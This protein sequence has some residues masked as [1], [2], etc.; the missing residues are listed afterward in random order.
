MRGTVSGAFWGLVLGTTGLGI[1]SLVHEQPVP[2]NSPQ[3][4]QIAAPQPAEGEVIAVPLVQ[5]APDPVSSVATD[6]PRMTPPQDVAEQAVVDA[7]PAAPPPAVV[8]GPAP[9]EP[10]TIAPETDVAA[11]VTT[12]DNGTVTN[13]APK[14]PPAP[15]AEDM[16]PPA[17][18]AATAEDPPA[19]TPAPGIVDTPS[20]APAAQDTADLAAP[21]PAPNV[22]PE[23]APQTA[24]VGGPDTDP[25]APVTPPAVAPVNDA[26]VGTGLAR[27]P[28]AMAEMPADV[29]PEPVPAQPDVDTGVG[30]AT[31]P[32]EDAS[33]V[34]PE[35][36]PQIVAETASPLPSIG[37]GVQVNRPGV[38]VVPSVGIPSEIAVPDV[39][40]EDVAPLTRYAAAF[41]NPQDLPLVSI[42]LL[43]D[44]TLPDA[45]AAVAALPFAATVILD[46][47]N[48]GAAE[49]MA[50]Y[51]AAG[52]EVGLQVALPF[53][54]RAQ[55]VEVAFQ[56]AFAMVPES[57]VMFSGGEDLLQSDR[58]VTGQV[59]AVLAAEGLGLIAV[60]RGLNNVA[61]IAEAAGVPAATVLRSLDEGNDAAAVGRALDQAAFRARQGTEGIVVIAGATPDMLDML[62]DW[63]LGGPVDQ[64]ALAPAS[65]LL[66]QP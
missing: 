9:S 59:V 47:L 32:V 4:P 19:Q 22:A 18:I 7:E 66:I 40:D 44:G 16:D 11:A 55:D 28:R 38:D 23:P 6:A 56:A 53:G 36:A 15:V 8:D 60:E 49:R 46:P 17:E 29:M 3:M 13:I 63:A 48:A 37:S 34:A 57:V 2:A 62:A 54:A 58:S 10:V 20:K 43:D 45:A 33:D 14:A 25:P 24:V 27:E 1:A 26:T 51:R 39:A 52:I 21:V 35:P 41:E 42:V 12:Q 50:A 5:D 64:V 30:L 61:R 65:A 31:G